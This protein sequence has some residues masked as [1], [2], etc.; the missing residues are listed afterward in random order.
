MS[1]QAVQLGCTR[2]DRQ[3]FS[4]I[5][6]EIGPGD[7]LR[8][9]GTNGS[10]KTSMLRMLCGLAQPAA[11]EIRWK[12]RDIH[13]L[14]EEYCSQMIYL[15]HANGVKD[16]MLAWENVLV[17]STLSGEIISRED[18]LGALARL[19]LGAAAKLPTRVLSQGQRKR[20]ALAR[21]SFGSSAPLW[22]LDEP[23]TALDRHAVAELCGTINA[24]LA[25]GGMVVFTTHQ[26]IELDAARFHR[27][28]LTVDE[29]EC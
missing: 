17:S 13:T 11:G 1:L 6:F 24:H 2:G 19:G 18:A 20:V 27:V 5:N 14:R 22:I 4:G 23:F 7:A 21:L 15:G 3:L 25:G 8:L 16:D 9:V 28:D 12:G 10:G 29:E 26:E